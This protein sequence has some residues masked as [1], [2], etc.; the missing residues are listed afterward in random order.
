MRTR[1][2]SITIIGWFLLVSGFL[3]LPGAFGLGDDP[4]VREMLARQPVPIAVQQGMLLAGAVANLV[5]GYFLLRGQN[6]A[7][8]LYVAWT[9]VQL[10]YAWLV[11]P[12]RLVIVP[13]A[14]VFLLIAYLLFRP[15]AN[16]F[17]AG[18][19]LVDVVAGEISPRRAFGIGSY[20]VAG[21]FLVCSSFVG[22][23]G[24]PWE[25]KW[26]MLG[27]ML[28]PA[29]FFLWIGRTLSGTP[30]WLRDVGV[31]LLASAAMSVCMALS[32]GLLA[33][34]PEFQKMMPPEPLNAYGT[35]GVWI[36]AMGL[37]GWAAFFTTGRKR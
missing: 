10:G 30:R 25:T 32:M 33:S 13:G 9:L 15:R 5:S 29:L 37:A 6:W 21:S 17:F 2:V 31:V 1:P 7:R 14:I 28:L 23:M 11:M 20:V 4:Q 12:Y 16:A 26:G 34:D 27:M 36:V 3:T 24:V 19:A 18:G 8:H 35:G 22:L